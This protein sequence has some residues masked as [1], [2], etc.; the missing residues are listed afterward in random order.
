MTAPENCGWN[1]AAR[2]DAGKLP[3][4]ESLEGDGISFVRDGSSE[5]L[6]HAPSEFPTGSPRCGVHFAD[7]LFSVAP[8]L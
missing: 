6:G 5:L 7:E 3:P 2:P 1:G 4:T 8:E